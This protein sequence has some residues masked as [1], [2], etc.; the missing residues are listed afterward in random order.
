MYTMYGDVTVPLVKWEGDKDTFKSK[1]KKIES[2]EREWERERED[3]W[4]VS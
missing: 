2:I 4:R 3:E 1:L